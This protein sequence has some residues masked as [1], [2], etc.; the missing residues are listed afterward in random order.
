MSRFKVTAALW[1]VQRWVGRRSGTMSFD[2]L[3]SA[4]CPG[5]PGSN[6]WT[7]AQR[8]DEYKLRLKRAACYTSPREAPKSSNRPGIV[9]R[10]APISGI[11]A[12][13]QMAQ[14]A[15]R[16]HPLRSQAALQ[17]VTDCGGLG[18]GIRQFLHQAVGV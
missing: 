10:A 1:R 12:R 11:M 3:V 15:P 16:R 5:L 14:T 2:S 13:D 6:T 17:G 8:S 18:A 9:M 4:R 7:L